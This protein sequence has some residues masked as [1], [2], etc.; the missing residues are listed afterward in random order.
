MCKFEPQLGL[1]TLMEIVDEILSTA[2]FSL[3]VRNT[4]RAVA[5][6]PALV[7]VLALASTAAALTKML[8]FYVEVFKTLYFLN[9]IFIFGIII[10]VGP[11]I[12]RAFSPPLL[13]T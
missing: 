9:V 3:P 12:Y 13:M 8:K 11:K 1:I 10:D 2:I 6:T 4:G 5:L 7:S